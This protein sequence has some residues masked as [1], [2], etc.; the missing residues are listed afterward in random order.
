MNTI[1]TIGAIDPE[2]LALLLKERD[3]LRTALKEHASEI[4]RLTSD[5]IFEQ[6]AGSLSWIAQA[7]LKEELAAQR[8]MLEQ[9]RDD[10][11][12]LRAMVGNLDIPRIADKFV[13]RLEPEIQKA[14]ARDVPL[15]VGVEQC[16]CDEEG[17]GK[18]GVSCGDCPKDYAEPVQERKPLPIERLREIER[19]HVYSQTAT[20]IEFARA[21]EFAH[22]IKETS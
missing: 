5:V 19:Q 4:E 18:P 6:Q 8:G 2:A 15:Q 10:M 12:T 14:E 1:Y 20:L 11:V 22:N 16:W 17:V 7:E 9:V 3:E 13:K 21:V